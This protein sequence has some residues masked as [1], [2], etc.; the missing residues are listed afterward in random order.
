MNEQKSPAE[1]PSTGLR[2]TVQHFCISCSKIR[3][4]S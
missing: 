4:A 2:T 1:K 3:L